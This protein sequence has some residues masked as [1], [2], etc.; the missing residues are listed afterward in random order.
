MTP[1]KAACSQ[2]GLAYSQVTRALS[3]LS[4]RQP[5]EPICVRQQW[6][7]KQHLRRGQSFG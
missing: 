3:F 2:R 5:M 1:S 7:K 4:G 6:W